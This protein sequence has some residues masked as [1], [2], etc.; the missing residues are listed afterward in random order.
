M[1]ISELLLTMDLLIRFD[2]S[3]LLKKGERFVIVSWKKSVAYSGTSRQLS[4][5]TSLVL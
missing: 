3:L 1:V 4:Q 5:V 2:F